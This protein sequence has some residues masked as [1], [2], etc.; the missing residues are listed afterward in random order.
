MS[1]RNQ[2]KRYNIKVYGKVQGVWYRAYTRDKAI[3]LGLT[4]WVRNKPDGSVEI[5]VEGDEE[6]IKELIKWCWKGSPAAKV[7][8]V[9]VI[10]KKF[11][12]EFTYFS[13]LY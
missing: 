6:K 12:N 9:K 11:N 4:G 10:E 13:I 3:E 5:E 7:E 2:K 8:N 1:S